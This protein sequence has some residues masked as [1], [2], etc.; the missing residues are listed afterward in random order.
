M[1]ALKNSDPPIIQDE[2][3]F[4]NYNDKNEGLIRS[5]KDDPGL[6]KFTSHQPNYGPFKCCSSL[7]DA[8]IELVSSGECQ[9]KS[10]FEK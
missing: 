10:N 4:A 3:Q 2:Y 6:I 7:V 5:E 1:C 8:Y 9:T